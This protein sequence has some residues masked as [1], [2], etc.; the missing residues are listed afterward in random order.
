EALPEAARDEINAAS[1]RLMDIHLD[2]FAVGQAQG[3]LAAANPRGALAVTP[4]V[5]EWLPKWYDTFSAEERQM[6][7]REVIELIA[8]GL[9]PL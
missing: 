7:A 3:T 6:A 4:G 2:I 9:R 8:L 1:V 5:Y